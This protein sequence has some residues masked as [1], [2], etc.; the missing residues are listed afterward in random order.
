MLLI[1]L[2]SYSVERG[3]IG[4]NVGGDADHLNNNDMYRLH[5]WCTK[6]GK[7]GQKLENDRYSY[8]NHNCPSCKEYSANYGRVLDSVNFFVTPQEFD[9]GTMLLRIDEGFYKAEFVGEHIC[10]VDPELTYPFH[11][12]TQNIPSVNGQNKNLADVS[13]KFFCF[14]YLTNGDVC[15]IL[16][17]NSG[18]EC[19][20]VLFGIYD[21]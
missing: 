5:A 7:Y 1:K 15:I 8:N 9:D 17:Q 10:G 21:R 14:G 18:E 3:N 11:S 16:S 6:C 4:N 12:I 20:Y 19:P 2:I 13:C